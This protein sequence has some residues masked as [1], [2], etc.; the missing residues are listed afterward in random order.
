MLINQ[1]HTK[2]VDS[3]DPLNI[4][5][6]LLQYHRSTL[7]QSIFGRMGNSLL[8]Y[9][10][11]V[12]VGQEAEECMTSTISTTTVVHVPT[13]TT[14]T[15]LQHVTASPFEMDPQKFQE[16]HAEWLRYED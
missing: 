4:T 10:A 2:Y 11:M 5:G 14:T 3:P 6:C 7:N 15:N 13:M 8:R 12:V 9:S 1:S 16:L